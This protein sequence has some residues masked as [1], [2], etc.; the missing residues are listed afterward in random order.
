MAISQAVESFWMQLAESRLIPAQQ[1]KVVA[2]ELAREGV[3]SDALVAKKLVQRGL[4]TRYQADRLLE[5]RSRG[6]FFDQYKLLDVLGMGGM[7]WV[8]RAEN[9]ETGEIVALKI[10]LDQLKNDHGMLARFE[11]EA[12]AGLRFHHENIVRTYA[13]GSAGGLPYV[14][15]EFVE[16]PSL[17]ELLRIRERCRLPWEQACEI[18]RQAA[19]G[20]HHVHLA[21]FV[22][23]DVKPQNLLIDRHGHVKLLDFGL[24]MMRDGEEGDEFSMA[25]IFGHEC[26]GTAA[27]TAPEQATDSLVADARS[28]IY[29]LGCTLY[30]SLTGDTP[31]PYPSTN[32]VLK[33]HQTQVPRNVCDIVSTVPRAVGDI[34]AKMLAKQPQDRFSSAADVATELS[35]WAKSTAVEFDFARILAERNKSAN[36]KLAEFHK[37]QRTPSNSASSTARPA[38]ISSVAIA[39]SDELPALGPGGHSPSSASSVTRRGPFGFEH[40]PPILVR[41][42]SDAGSREDLNSTSAL[43]S[44]MVLLPLS[45]G[46]AIPLA[47]S[48]FAIGR[49]VD[50]DL[51]IQDASVSTRHCEL[52]YDGYQWTIVDLKSRNGV[53]VNGELVQ[54]QRLQSGDTIVI[55]SSLRLRFSDARGESKAK[56]PSRFHRI[57]IAFFALAF[58]AISLAAIFWLWPIGR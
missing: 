17:L 22:H 50:C 15:M 27:F 44:G 35:V 39:S 28:D 7:G 16:G 43:K 49:A 53:R 52:R 3:A 8:Y 37:R 38:S 48:R 33:A 45:G 6:F 12:R 24:A 23:R 21:G 18:T 11:Q 20:L 40:Q 32:D 42:Q 1:V 57:L 58:V 30:A 25:M 46:A 19:L 56:G 26:V 54:R 10:L 4:L 14:I 51:Q 13:C 2:R 41:Q 29:S 47:K 55:G 34:V 9:T 31:F 5:G 36:E